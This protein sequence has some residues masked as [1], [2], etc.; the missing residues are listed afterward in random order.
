MAALDEFLDMAE[1][2]LEQAAQ[3]WNETGELLSPDGRIKMAQVYALT[4]IARALHE[5]NALHRAAAG[6]QLRAV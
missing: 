2:Q 4:S 3:E 5:M 6:G 1:E